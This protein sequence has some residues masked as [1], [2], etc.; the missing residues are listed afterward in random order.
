MDE[1][2]AKKDVKLVKDALDQVNK[3]DYQL[4]LVEYYV[5]WIMSWNRR[6]DTLAWKDKVRARQLINNAIGIINDSPTV[7]KLDPYIDQLFSLLPTS[8]LPPEA[9]NRLKIG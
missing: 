5:A 4:A 9:K 6:F 8:A 7:E 1:A 3:L 2:I